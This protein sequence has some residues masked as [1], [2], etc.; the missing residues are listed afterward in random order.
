MTPKHVQR[1]EKKIADIKR[2][3]AAE[4]RLFGGYDDSRGLRYLPTRYYLQ[5]GDYKGGLAYTRWFAKAFPDDAGFPE[6]LFE[7]TVLL[8]K[9]GKLPEAQHN[10]WQTF[11]ANTYVL[12]KFVGRPIESIAKFE[13]SAYA[14]VS[15]AD[16]F[17]YS[18][19]QA[20]LTHF[21]SWLEAFLSSDEFIKHSAQYEA[22]NKRLESEVDRETRVYLIKQAHQLENNFKSY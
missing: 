14:E 9:A 17:S 22:I 19:R 15:F 21:S 6:F 4:K 7:W 5:L 11:C 2:A 20:E 1:L 3:L 10:A 13:G 12:D 8:F 16:S 18:S